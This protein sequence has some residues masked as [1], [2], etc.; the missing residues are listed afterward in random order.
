[1]ALLQPLSAHRAPT[2]LSEF[3]FPRAGLRLTNYFDNCEST[4]KKKK[5]V[6]SLPA[7]GRR[8]GDRR[9]PGG[10]SAAS[11]V[12]P[13]QGRAA[14]ALSPPCPPFFLPSLLP[15]EAGQAEGE[16]GRDRPKGGRALLAT[17]PGA[18]RRRQRHGGEPGP[19]PGAAPRRQAW[20]RPGWAKG[21][22]GCLSPSPSAVRPLERRG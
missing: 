5:K 22:W 17:R 18:S 16:P 20:G 3:T 10:L 14:G 9:C 12:Q 2:A 11:A 13:R 1:M 21:L 7:C 8:R 6:S 19:R 15:W 4:L